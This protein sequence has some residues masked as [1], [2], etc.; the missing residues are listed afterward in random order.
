EGRCACELSAS[1]ELM[2][3]EMLYG[4]VFT[5]LTPAQIAALLSCFVFQES[6]KT[7]RVPEELSDCLRK[8]HEYARRIAK[9]SVECEL[10]IIEDKYVE[11]FK[12][13]MMNIV[14][15]WVHGTS[16]GEIIKNSDIFEG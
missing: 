1:D 5:D 15:R 14:Y 8:L 12:P 16:F 11:S 3:T 6:A 13:G 9:L 4:G 7:P 10:D 2:L